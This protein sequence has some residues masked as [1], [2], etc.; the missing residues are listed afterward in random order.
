[1]T[2]K[3]ISPLP[4]LVLLLSSLILLPISACIPTGGAIGSIYNGRLKLDSVYRAFKEMG[5]Q[6]IILE[7]KVGGV[8]LISLR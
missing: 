2:R 3:Y 6:A 8:K 5:L 4:L 1:M 7:E